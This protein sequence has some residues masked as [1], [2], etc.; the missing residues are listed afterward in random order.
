MQ[1]QHLCSLRLDADIR[2][3]LGRLPPTLEKLY[4]EVYETLSA[5]PAEF[6]NA[7]LRNVLTWL[8][9]AQRPLNEAEFLT[10]VS[11]IPNKGFEQVSKDQVLELCNNFV[12]FDQQLNTF[13]LAHLSVREFLEKRAEYTE[14]ATNCLAAQIC[15]L[16]LISTAPNSAARRFLCEYGFHLVNKPCFSNAFSI[17]SN[18]YWPRH[19]QLAAAERTHGALQDVFL[20]FLAHETDSTSPFAIWSR[21]VPRLLEHGVK[22]D[23]W[24]KLQDTIA[25][26]ASASIVFLGTSFDFSEISENEQGAQIPLAKLTNSQGADILQV[27][28]RWGSCKMMASLLDRRGADFQITE[29]VV[30]AAAGNGG[31]EVMTLLLD[32]RGTGIQITEGMVKAAAGNW[33]SGEEVM[34]LLLDRRGADV[35]VTEEVVKAAAGNRRGDKVIALLLDRRGADVQIAEVVKAAAGNQWGGKVIAL[36]LDR[37]GADVQIT[38]EVVK[39]AAGNEWGGK[40]VMTLL[41]DRRGIDIQITEEVVK[42]AAGNLLSGKEVMTLLLDRRGADIQITEGVV[43]AAAGNPLSGKEVMTLLL[44]RRGTDVQITEEVVKAATGNVVSGKEV[45]TLLLDRRGADVQLIN[46][47]GGSYG[48][49]LQAASQA[50][51]ESLVRLLLDGGA[52]I[53]AQGGRYGTALHAASQGGHESVVRLLLDR[54]ADIHAQGGRYGTA[55]HAASQGGHESVVRLLL[56]RGADV[57]AKS[58]DGQ[59]ALHISAERGDLSI[60]QLLL[61]TGARPSLVDQHGWTPEQCAMVSGDEPTHSLFAKPAITEKLLGIAPKAWSVIDHSNFCISPN[62]LE[63]GPSERPG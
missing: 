17:Y 57:N 32:R 55:L 28:I 30:M 33:T 7:V 4:V 29:E 44:D 14:A 62:G 34:T 19:C 21:Q 40:E 59:T 48:I 20:F 54:G 46:A 10:A 49:A 51:R 42:A 45:M 13:R 24:H 8:L 60:T 6:G 41:L 23:L 38:E 63:A 31:K 3:R 15:L 39:A 52:N 25:A 53:H 22:W 5:G 58:W 50:G 16:N 11:I 43:Q 12:V 26:S 61:G 37:R 27:C 47:E 2:E 35:Q 18:I 1:L 36:L 9:C 56:D